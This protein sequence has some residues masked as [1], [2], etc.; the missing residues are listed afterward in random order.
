MP[1]LEAEALATEMQD[2]AEEHNPPPVMADKADPGP[3]TE[4]RI[5]K[6]G[7]Y[8]LHTRTR[9]CGVKVQ[10]ELTT[11]GPQKDLLC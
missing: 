8:N 1:L 2:R 10:E 3:T 9:R 7:A 5:F 4:A 6:P 11:D